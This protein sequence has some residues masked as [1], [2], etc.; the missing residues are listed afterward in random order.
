TEM[1]TN[2]SLDTDIERRR[3]GIKAL[4]DVANRLSATAPKKA[5]PAK[6]ALAKKAV[7]SSRAPLE[8]ERL[9]AI[10]DFLDKATSGDQ[11]RQFL[12]DQK[13]SIA[14]IRQISD[15]KGTHLGN[16]RTRADLLESLVQGRVQSRINFEVLSTLGHKEPGSVLGK[17]EGLEPAQ[18]IKKVA[19]ATKAVRGDSGIDFKALG[20]SMDEVQ[21]RPEA[22]ALLGKLSIGQ[23]REVYKARERQ[24]PPGARTK[25]DL[26][27]GL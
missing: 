15:S 26:V 1:N 13:L 8:P 4:R 20:K 9:G 22:E 2:Q 10:N 11:A 6:A 18:A 19:N 25:K 21:T 27:E 17:S 7:P 23:L 24:V 16:A 5:A 3:I 12:A 14:Q